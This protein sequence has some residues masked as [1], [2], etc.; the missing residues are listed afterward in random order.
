VDARAALDDG[1]LVCLFGEG[2][3]TRSGGGNRVFNV[4][5]DARNSVTPTGFAQQLSAA[6][7]QQAAQ[8]LVTSILMLVWLR[9][10]KIVPV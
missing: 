5:V 6:I 8:M 1:L 3:L 10:G 4:N 7:L 9:Y 2:A